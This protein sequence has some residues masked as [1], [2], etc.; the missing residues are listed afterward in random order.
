MKSHGKML[1]DNTHIIWFEQPTKLGNMES[2][3]Y[4]IWNHMK[5]CCSMIL[6]SYHLNNLPSW[7]ILR[8]MWPSDLKSHEKMLFNNYPYHLF[9]QPTKLGNIESCDYQ[10]WNHMEKCCLTIPISCD[11]NNLPNWAI[12]SHVT[13]RYEITWKNA[14][15]WYPY[16]LIWTTYPI[17]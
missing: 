3:D 6:I 14:V 9:E 5:K 16:Q 11:L 13:I 12:E 4:Q 8:V 15:Q 17:E 1:F 7:V 2:C 10:M